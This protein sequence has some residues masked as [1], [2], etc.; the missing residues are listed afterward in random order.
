[1]KRRTQ[2]ILALVSLILAGA[3]GFYVYTTFNQMVAAPGRHPAVTIPAGALID[4]KMLTT[5]EVPRPLLDEAIYA[6]AADVIGQVAA[7]PLRPGMVVY[8][9][10]VV[11]QQQYRLVDDPTL[12]VVSFPVNPARAVGRCSPAITWTC[13]GW[14]ACGPRPRSR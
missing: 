2:L 6:N 11:S 14:Q 3:A 10:F 1:M 8:R 13:G 4:M 7:I 12:E 5:R 9:S